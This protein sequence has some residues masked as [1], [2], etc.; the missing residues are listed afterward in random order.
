MINFLYQ[1]PSIK[2]ENDYWY[3]TGF[4]LEEEIFKEFIANF[5]FS[6]YEKY[7]GTLYKYLSY[8]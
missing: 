4:I 2:Y 5:N 6:S 3:H 7:E 1:R 8:L